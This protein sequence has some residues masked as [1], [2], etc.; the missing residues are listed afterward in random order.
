MQ[1]AIIYAEG[2]FLGG[3]GGG[4]GFIHAEGVW[5]GFHHPCRRPHR[6]AGLPCWR[7]P[8]EFVAEILEVLWADAQAEHF[9][10]HGK[11][12]SQRTNREQR[13]GIGGPHQAARRRQ[14]ECVF[15]D[16]RGDAALVEL[17]GQHAVR[18]ADDPHCTRRFAI[19]FQ[20][21]ANKF[22][23]AAAVI[24]G[25]ALNLADLAATGRRSSPC[26]SS[27]A[28]DSGAPPPSAG[29]PRSSATR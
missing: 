17:R 3:S 29:C 16:A 23:P 15:D 6:R 12:I 25:G 8:F 9:F 14:D 5:V 13:W 10:D 22:F 11:E 26:G 21:P 7:D 27:V 1:R 2:V 24:H 4:G 18:T 28:D 20:N 19:R